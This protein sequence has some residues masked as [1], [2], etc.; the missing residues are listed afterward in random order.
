MGWLDEHIEGFVIPKLKEID[1]ESIKTLSGS[2]RPHLDIL[3]KD[4][5]DTIGK[6]NSEPL[7]YFTSEEKTVIKNAWR[8]TKKAA[9]NKPILLAGR[10]VFIFEVLARRENYPTKFIPECSRMTASHLA[11]T[12]PNVKDYFLFDTGFVGSIPRALGI[13]NF[14]LFSWSRPLKSMSIW[15]DSDTDINGNKQIFPRMTWSRGL[16]LKIELTPKYWESGRMSM[17]G[18]EILQPFSSRMEFEN[19][20]RLTI[21][22]YKDS[23]PKFVKKHQPIGSQ[24]RW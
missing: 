22:I 18:Q 20:A 2:G 16:A 15:D 14:N 7:G 3:V 19:A 4:I 11:K 8:A 24:R 17:Y 9:G 12:I 5:E 13:D 21:E 23:S 6:F 1:K 10:D